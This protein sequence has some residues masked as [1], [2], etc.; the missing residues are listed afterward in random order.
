MPR[1]EQVFGKASHVFLPVVHA[2]DEDQVVR[3]MKIAADNGADGVF[4]INHRIRYTQLFSIYDEVREVFPTLWIGLNCL[5]KGREVVAIIPRDVQGLWADD[6]GV[7]DCGVQ[8]NFHIFQNLRSG[9][10]WKG[11]YFGGVAFKGQAFV[12]D[13]AL[14]AKLAM[15]HIDVVTTSGPKTG[16]PPPLS[17]IRSMRQA[18]G[19][20][21]LVIASGMT[22]GNIDLYLPFCDG[23][24]VSTG[25]S[26]SF[27]ELDPRATWE[28]AKRLGK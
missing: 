13:P 21:P 20:H 24:L 3:N 1:F 27:T 22:V 2:E 8:D 9:V 28:F 10:N 15:P 25:I 12:E 18:I 23:I 11:L 7:T 16:E 17:K 5:D 14:A 6:G 4:L 26:R 19:G